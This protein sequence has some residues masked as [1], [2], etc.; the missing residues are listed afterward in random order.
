MTKLG[1]IRIAVAKLEKFWDVLMINWCSYSS[2]SR[3][4]KD[5][6]RTVKRTSS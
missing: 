5:L 3:G 6:I 2:L 4:A 1:T